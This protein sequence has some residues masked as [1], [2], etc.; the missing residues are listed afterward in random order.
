MG[1]RLRL[2]RMGFGFDGMDGRQQQSRQ[3]QQQTARTSSAASAFLRPATSTTAAV[4]STSAGIVFV[5]SRPSIGTRNLPSFSGNCSNKWISSFSSSWAWMFFVWFFQ[6]ILLS[7][8]VASG[9]VCVCVCV[10]W[11][12]PLW[13][14][15]PPLSSLD[16]GTLLPGLCRDENKSLVLTFRKH[17]GKWTF[18]STEGTTQKIKN[19][20]PYPLH[21]HTR[22]PSKRLFLLIKI[23]PD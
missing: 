3:Q 21:T 14:Y 2:E 9:C 20:N 15:P 8:Y 17:S 10:G 12:T 11:V 22:L 5:G 19:K 18:P 1:L 13:A 4:T 7:L 16:S 23:A 6:S